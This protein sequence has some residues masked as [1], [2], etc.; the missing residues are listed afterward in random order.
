MDAFI[1]FLKGALR[2]DKDQRWTPQMA[3]THPFIARETY[4]GHF[5]PRREKEGGGA[6]ETI[7]VDENASDRSF[8]S[9]DSKE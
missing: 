1:D 6:N 2:I 8:S 3:M 7:H 4:T 9:K 5:E